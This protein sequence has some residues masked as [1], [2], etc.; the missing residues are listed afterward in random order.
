MVE[1]IMQ[2][3]GWVTICFTLVGGLVAVLRG[4]L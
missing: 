2:A 4:F 1:T 3:A